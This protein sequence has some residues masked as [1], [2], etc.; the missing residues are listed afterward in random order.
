MNYA[1]DFLQTEQEHTVHVN[2]GTVMDSSGK[3]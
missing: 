3:V 2:T 1:R